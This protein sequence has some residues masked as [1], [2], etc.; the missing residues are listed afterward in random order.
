MLLACAISPYKL[1]T[2]PRTY[3]SV[4][5]SVL[6]A[7]PVVQVQVYPPLQG[8]GSGEVC[9]SLCCDQQYRVD[10]LGGYDASVLRCLRHVYR[11]S[12]V[13]RSLLRV[14]YVYRLSDLLYLHS[15]RY[16]HGG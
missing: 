1:L 12:S 5:A 14:D 6:A 9:T 16:R 10:Y 13:V 11:R 8:A 15:G 7:A 4:C 3:T 2:T